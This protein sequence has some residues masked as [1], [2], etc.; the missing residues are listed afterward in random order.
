[1]IKVLKIHKYGYAVIGFAVG[2]ILGILLG[3]LH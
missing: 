2:F 1:M 3:L